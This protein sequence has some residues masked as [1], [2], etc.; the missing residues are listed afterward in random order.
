MH[1]KVMDPNGPEGIRFPTSDLPHPVQGL[2]LSRVQ[3]I[4]QCRSCFASIANILLTTFTIASVSKACR[5]VCSYPSSHYAK[6]FSLALPRNAV[7]M[8]LS[9][10]KMTV[11]G[12]FSLWGGVWDEEGGEIEANLKDH[13]HLLLCLFC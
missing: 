5:A 4:V 7:D 9:Y 8:M 10:N 1:I 12:S 3:H 6:F 13:R 2:P 11:K